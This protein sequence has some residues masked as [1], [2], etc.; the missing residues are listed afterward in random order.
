[1]NIDQD[2]ITCKEFLESHSIQIDIKALKSDSRMRDLNFRRSLFVYFLRKKG[3]TLQSVASFLNRKTHATVIN[4]E[5]YLHKKQARDPRY[6]T[7]I[8]EIN[9]RFFYET[10]HSTDIMKE[11]ESKIEFHK[12]ALNKYKLA[13]NILL[14]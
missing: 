1:M 14:K 9:A 6:S 2:I 10:G 8:P 12:N 3:H 11:I 7:I 13:R 4:L 5:N